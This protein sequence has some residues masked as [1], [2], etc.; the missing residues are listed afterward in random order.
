MDRR[1][2]ERLIGDLAIDEVRNCSILNFVRENRVLSIYRVGTSTL[3]RGRSD[4]DWIYASSSNPSEL[5]LL[6]RRLSEDDEYYAA[7]EPWM[8]SILRRDREIAWSLP[9]VRFTLRDWI[10]LPEADGAT[11]PLSQD[12]APTVYEH[13]DYAEFISLD[14]AR[15]RILAGPAFGVREDDVLVAWCMTQDDGAMGFL[16]VVD[17]YRNRGYG[18]RITIALA[19]EL[20][21]LGRRPFAYISESNGSAISL[22]TALGF[23]RG[24]AVQWFRLIG[25]G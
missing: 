4:R 17:Q 13:S 9:M 25:A 8:V 5:R 7:I 23:E 16:H 20:R 12:D 18:R 3:V 6:A 11:V 21:R 22:V 24:E 19:A 1:E 10:A 2:I 14:Y 15:T